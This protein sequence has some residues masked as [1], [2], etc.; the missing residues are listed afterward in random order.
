MQAKYIRPSGSLT[1]DV[2]EIAS[3]FE[4]LRP[5][6]AVIEVTWTYRWL[7]HLLSPMRTILLAHPLRLRDMIQRRSKTDRLEA[8]LL[9]S[10]AARSHAAA[11][12]TDAIPNRSRSY[13]L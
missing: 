12:E 11:H 2:A 4:K 13:E 6:R 3:A 8:Q 5:F 1:W 10:N 9:V 7:F